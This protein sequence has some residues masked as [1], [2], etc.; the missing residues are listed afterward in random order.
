MERRGDFGVGWALLRRSC[1]ASPLPGGVPSSPPAMPGH[2]EPPHSGG[3]GGR[4]GLVPHGASRQDAE[5]GGQ[6]GTGSRAG[7]RCPV[8]AGERS[9]PGWGG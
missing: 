1:Q 2:G 5:E 6:P 3:G 4:R 8:E 7:M 9:A